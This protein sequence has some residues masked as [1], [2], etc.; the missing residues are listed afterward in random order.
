MSLY[1]EPTQRSWV[2]AKQLASEQGSPNDVDVITDI[3][4]SNLSESLTTLQQL[5]FNDDMDTYFLSDTELLE[6][7][8]SKLSK[9]KIGTKGKILRKYKF[10]YDQFNEYVKRGANEMEATVKASK[11]CGI[12][13][14]TFQKFIWLK[15]KDVNYDEI[16]DSMHLDRDSRA[17]SHPI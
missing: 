6:S 4:K 5:Y 11:V 12:D 10:A 13:T 16:Y 9:L 1:T 2:K 3:F 17:I 14:R 8:S 7:I 15:S